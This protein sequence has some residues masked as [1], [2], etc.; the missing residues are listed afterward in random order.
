[1][2]N[3]N[4]LNGKRKQKSEKKFIS[5]KNFSA[6]SI[7][8]HETDAKTKLKPNEF[9]RHK[10]PLNELSKLEKKLIGRASKLS[11]NKFV[12]EFFEEERTET[13]FLV[14]CFS[15]IDHFA[16]G[17][18]EQWNAQTTIFCCSI[19][20]QWRRNKRSPT[21]NHRF[22]VVRFSRSSRTR[23][24]SSRSRNQTFSRYSWAA[25]SL[26]FTDETNG[27][28]ATRHQK[29]TSTR[30]SSNKFVAISECSS[31]I[32]STAILN[33]ARPIMNSYLFVFLF[34]E[35]KQTRV[36]KIVYSEFSFVFSQIFLC[37][38]LKDRKSVV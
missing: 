6:W 3:S 20:K 9:D 29:S 5:K 10:P 17:T 4:T 11:K 34:L 33:F 7:S 24:D 37:L 31:S 27:I 19:F 32:F 12:S 22:F 13:F 30:T 23:S 25:S 1:M 14:R 16:E 36:R 28:A 35:R 18:T 15:S 8:R 2:S 38:F 21:R 26:S